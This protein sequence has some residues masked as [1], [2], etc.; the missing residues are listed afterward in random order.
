MSVENWW[1]DTDKGKLEILEEKLVPVPLC[2]PQI[3]CDL[4]LDRT[5]VSMGRCRHR[6]LND[7]TPDRCFSLERNM[8]TLMSYWFKVCFTTLPVTVNIL[9]LVTGW[10]VNDELQRFWMEAAVIGH[11]P[12]GT[13]ISILSSF[14]S[15]PVRIRLMR[16][17]TSLQFTSVS[18]DVSIGV[19]SRARRDHSVA[20]TAEECKPRKVL[21]FNFMTY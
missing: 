1:N 11:M 4:A 18:V 2:P 9:L 21:I 19:H 5:R 3:P 15:Q 16:V 8:P 7:T 13:D 20:Y 6:L 12:E 14:P 10:S 17:S